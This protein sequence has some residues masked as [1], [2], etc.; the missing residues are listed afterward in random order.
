MNTDTQIEDRAVKLYAALARTL[1]KFTTRDQMQ[2]ML[3]KG[4]FTKLGPPL[5]A[6][7]KTLVVEVFGDLAL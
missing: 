4:D 3:A 7:L 2:L 5:Q 1:D 6:A